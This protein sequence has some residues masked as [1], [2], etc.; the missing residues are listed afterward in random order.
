MGVVNIGDYITGKRTVR[1]CLPTLKSFEANGF[2][3]EARNGGN[4]ERD[5]LVFRA[6]VLKAAHGCLILPGGTF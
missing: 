6:S 2:I 5:L 3:T 1:A 4:T